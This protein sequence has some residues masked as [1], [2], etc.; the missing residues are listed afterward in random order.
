MEKENFELG[1]AIKEIRESRLIT[2]QEL[3][4]ELGITVN[5]LSQVENG[6]R[7][8]SPRNM[9][10]IAEALEVPQSFLFVLADDGRKKAV[11]LLQNLVYKSLA[12]QSK[13]MAKHK[14]GT[15]NVR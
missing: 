8:V 4:V 3:A 10:K 11:G 14:R 5:F 6:R 15:A 7:G 13:E 12:A 1:A 2:Q 9:E